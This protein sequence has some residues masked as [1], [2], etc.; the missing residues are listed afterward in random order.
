MHTGKTT[1]DTS[2]NVGW[3]NSRTTSILRMVTGS[4]TAE[5]NELPTML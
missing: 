4:L 3:R 5:A 2:V 1:M